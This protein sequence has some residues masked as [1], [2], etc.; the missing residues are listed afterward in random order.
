[1]LSGL[2]SGEGLIWAVRDPIEKR[3]GVRKKGRTV[4]YETVTADHGVSDK[5]ALIIETEFLSPL[6]LRTGKETPSLP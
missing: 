2:S 6:A 3:E 4:G 5:R 1:M